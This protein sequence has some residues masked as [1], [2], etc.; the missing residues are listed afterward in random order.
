MSVF[1]I[2][3]EGSVLLNEEAAQLVPELKGISEKELRYIVLAYD[4]DDGPFRKLN[5][6]QRKSRACMTVFR[7]TDTKKAEEGLEKKIEAYRSLIY[8]P[9]KE[10]REV[11]KK[12]LIFLQNELE[13]ADT[14]QR[15]TQINNTCKAIEETISELDRE[16]EISDEHIQIRGTGTLSTIEKYQRRRDAY[17]ETLKS[18]E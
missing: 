6:D 16:I 3:E 8:D 4:Y 18:V 9:K 5:S 2:N 15:I 12:K 11:L 13:I 17:N 14:V 1:K 7:H 10:R